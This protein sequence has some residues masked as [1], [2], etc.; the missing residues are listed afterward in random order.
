L[1][2]NARGGRSEKKQVIR[3]LYERWRAGDLADGIA[4]RS[5]ITDAIKATG[6]A[7]SVGNAANF[8]K[9]LIRKGNVVENWPEEMIEARI[10]ARQR[11]GSER[12][13]QFFQHDPSWA[14]PFPDWHTPSETT[15][16]Y[17]V[18]SVSMD[19][20]ARSLGRSEE[21]WLT[22]IAVNLHLIHT[23]L[24]LFS[25]EELRARVWD[26]RHLQMS[27]KTQPEIDAAF[28]ATYRSPDGTGKEN[29]FLTLEAKQRDERI[30]VDQIREQVAKAFEITATLNDPPIHAVKPLALQVV[31]R[32]YEGADR[33]MFFLVEFSTVYRGSFNEHYSSIIGPEALYDM[34]LEQCSAALYH[35]EPPI[36]ALG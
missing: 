25:P 30:L 28:I 24:A 15:P 6:A 20:L 29:V 1:A 31:R 19:S 33:N 22:Q 9:D 10:S 5:D 35:L 7:L 32:R 36:P 4:Y 13:L 18:Q 11:Y 23:H 2:R 21:S 3:Y 26:V 17:R 16:I 12:V 8:L 34:K 14:S 27:V